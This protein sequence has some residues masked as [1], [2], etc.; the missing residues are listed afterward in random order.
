MN[1]IIT[2]Q[3][4]ERDN[5]LPKGMVQQVYIDLRGQKYSPADK[6]DIE[7][8]IIKKSNNIIQL[9]NIKFLEDE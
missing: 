1:N 9:D 7:K 3:A 5:H 2:E 6:K 4:K 8:R